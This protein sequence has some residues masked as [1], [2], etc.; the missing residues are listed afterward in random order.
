MIMLR[1]TNVV[2][3]KRPQTF[4]TAEALIEKV[5]QE[6]FKDGGTYKAIAVKT[7]V[8]PTTIGNLA[9]GKTRWPRP[10]TLFPL[11]QSLGLEM[12]LVKQKGEKE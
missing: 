7:N 5:R 6:I 12:Q 1:P 9:M 4:T 8:S 10:T 2:Q 3:L 11:L